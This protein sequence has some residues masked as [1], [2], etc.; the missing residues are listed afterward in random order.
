[1]PLLGAAA[2]AMWW[3]IGADL[4]R[5]FED[6]HSHEH[7]PERLGLPGFLRGSRWAS[8]EDEEGFFVLYELASY[9]TLTSPAYRERLNNPTPW[10]QKMMPQH[11]NM[12]RSQCRVLAS[13]GTLLAGHLM[14]LRFSP[15]PGQAEALATALRTALT[16][17]AALPRI[18][19]AHLLRTDT[20][21][22]P[23]T[24]E[25]RLRGGRD[26]AADWILLVAG[27][28]AGRLGKDCEACLCEAQSE[29]SGVLTAPQ[30]SFFRLSH[31]ATAADLQ[32]APSVRALPT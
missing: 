1:M 3:S 28:E 16:R 13:A 23:E 27:F 18:A 25:Q 20:P 8:V 15:R 7:F 32:A 10:S 24:E 26:A 19:G 31:A 29:A 11:R 9:E 2:L 6:W 30:R 14:T 21:A 22:V 12:V 5:E 17:L 4:R